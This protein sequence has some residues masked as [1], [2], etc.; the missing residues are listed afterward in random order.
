MIVKIKQNQCGGDN[1]FGLPIQWGGDFYFA[2]SSA[3]AGDTKMKSSIDFWLSPWKNIEMLSPWKNIEICLPE[4]YW[5]VVSLKKYWNFV[6]L[7]KIVE[8]FFCKQ[9]QSFPNVVLKNCTTNASLHFCLVR[10]GIVNSFQCG[11]IHKLNIRKGL[12]LTFANFIRL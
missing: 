6:S 3:G 12:L 7:K 11:Q 8:S 2:A 4:K 1:C 10:D 9:H 5:N